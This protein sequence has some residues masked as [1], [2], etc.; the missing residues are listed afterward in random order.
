VDIKVQLLKSIE[1]LEVKDQI[2]A[3]LKGANAAN[4]EVFVEKGSQTIVESNGTSDFIQLVKKYQSENP[5]VK[6]D[7][8]F[9]IVSRSLEGRKAYAKHRK[10]DDTS[11]PRQA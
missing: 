4:A 11:T 10:L 1:S 5:D 6:Y 3:M 8:A 9:Q 2:V 7:Q